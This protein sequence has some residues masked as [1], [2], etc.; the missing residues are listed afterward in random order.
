[1]KT[2]TAQ[3]GSL[4]VFRP[5]PARASLGLGLALCA[6]LAGCAMQQDATRVSPASAG[7]PPLP[8]AASTASTAPAA[9]EPATRA[10]TDV[11][12]S[13]SSTASPSPTPTRSAVL[14]AAAPPARA[15][16]ATPFA[17]QH[18]VYTPVGFAELPGWTSD[19]LDQSWQAFLRSCRV[20]GSR[21]AWASTCADAANVDAADDAAIRAFY[22]RHFV[23]YRVESTRGEQGGL[24]TGYF[25]PVVHGSR[26]YG[27]RF[28]YPVYGVPRDML[29]LDA[30]R[31][32]PNALGT[33][34]V[35]RIVGRQVVPLAQVSTG[36]MSGVLALDLTGA[37]PDLRDKKIRMRLSG[38]RIVPYYTRAEIEQRGLQ[39][40]VIAY[41]E[42][43]AQLYTIQMQGSGKIVL[44]D[45]SVVRV[46][47][48]DQNGHP[49]SPS[50]V[51]AGA[52]SV[53]HLVLRGMEVEVAED[54]A[55]ASATAPTAGVGTPANMPANMQA[56]APSMATREPLA[57]KMADAR[58]AAAPGGAPVLLAGAEEEDQ[59]S[60]AGVP[61]AS[62][63]TG[64]QS[65][66]VYLLADLQSAG[67]A[68]STRARQPASG[69]RTNLGAVALPGAADSDG[70]G[71]VVKARRVSMH[72]PASGV[73]AAGELSPAAPFA[74]PARLFA[75]SDPSYVFFKPIRDNTDGPLGALGVPLS[76]GRSIAVDPRTTPLGAPVYLSARTGA[77]GGL[78]G[79][80]IAQDTGGAIS[81]AQRADLYS[82]SGMDA[83]R[84]AS[85]LKAPAR[86]W[87]LLPT[88]LNLASHGSGL[89]TTRG[90]ES[91]GNSGSSADCLVDDGFCVD[92]DSTP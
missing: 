71:S 69:G 8:V 84:V 52:R 9:A 77:T 31:V 68:G 15:R 2:M 43:P 30:H 85:T 29:Y 27:G 80:F 20:L 58:D 56:S 3:S 6:A 34:T 92:Y 44:Q 78:K 24:L 67:G 10:M 74:V 60:G 83:E 19:R 21:P 51:A 35:A 17:T 57:S 79:L 42:N 12:S 54:N 91:G 16:T 64:G 33:L 1:M 59:R 65:R 41:V 39:A 82:G 62:A 75:T 13:A 61:A 70:D 66:S 14:A 86:L 26:S 11:T 40:D 72:R 32:P 47:Y 81:G 7:A 25:E 76:A 63:R 49:F 38:R 23:V 88:G 22:E 46:A 89:R 28:V 45:E 87:V 73:S 4:P 50:V 5:P 48:A 90:G 37:V 53:Q 36:S 18:A 55:D